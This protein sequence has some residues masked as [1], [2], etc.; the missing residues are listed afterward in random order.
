MRVPEKVFNLR[1]FDLN[2][3]VLMRVSDYFDEESNF[4]FI[5][6][7]FLM[8]YSIYLTRSR[9]LEAKALENLIKS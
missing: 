1:E 6:Q 2:D 4:A 7:R 8:I 3:D 5:Y 9:Y